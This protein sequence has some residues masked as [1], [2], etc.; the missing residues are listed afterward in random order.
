MV[1][2]YSLCDCVYNSHIFYY[3]NIIYI[4]NGASTSSS[5]VK[6]THSSTALAYICVGVFIYIYQIKYYFYQNI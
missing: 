3:L 1:E 6:R 2:I 4:R 5:L